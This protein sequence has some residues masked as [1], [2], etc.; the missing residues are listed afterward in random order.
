MLKTCQ[1]QKT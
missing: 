1:E